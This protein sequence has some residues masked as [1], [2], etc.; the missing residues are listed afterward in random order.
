MSKVV[1][2]AVV[3][4]EP[5]A[6]FIAED[7][8]TLNWVLALKLIAPTDASRLP[9]GVRSQLRDAVAE[10]RWGDAVATWITHTGVAVDVYPST[11][12]YEEADVTLAS[13]EL[14]FRPLFE[15]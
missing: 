1:A 8:S 3:H 15:N 13:L 2:Y 7:L 11:E 12:L 4:D 5:P 14:Q 6:V 10:E 9:V